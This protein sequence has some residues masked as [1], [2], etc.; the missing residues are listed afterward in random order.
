MLLAAQT[1]ERVALYRKAPPPGDPLPIHVDKADILDGPP[2]NKELWSVVRG[3]RNGCAAGASGL[4]AEHIKVW[5]RNVTR[6]EEEDGDIGLGDKWRLFVKLMKAIWERGCVPEQM[7]WEIIVLLPKGNNDYCGIG[8]L[9][10]FWKVMEKNMVAQFASIKLHDFLHGG[11]LKRG[12][13]T[14][15]F[16]AKLHQ[17]LAWRDQCPLYQIYLCL[18]K[19]YDALD[20]E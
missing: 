8:L 18:K 12:T 17:S 2:S 19:A 5:L 16:E 13:G 11:L 15:T 4:R 14:A 1:A 3:L 7:R 20:R 9:D 10:P 6:K